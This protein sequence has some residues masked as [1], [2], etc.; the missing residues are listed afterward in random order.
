MAHE[1]KGRIVWHMPPSD[2]EAER[3]YMAVDTNQ[4]KHLAEIAAIGM[5]GEE[6]MAQQRDLE[7]I[8]AY[9]ARLAELDTAG[10]PEQTH[11]FGATGENRLRGDEVT[12]GDQAEELVAAAP[13]SKGP[14]F[15]VP[16]TVEE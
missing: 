14:Y 10:L 12:N 13:D 4:V 9:T 1:P 11:P 8:A 5:G 6:L 15:R 3:Q 16:R 2:E 7:R